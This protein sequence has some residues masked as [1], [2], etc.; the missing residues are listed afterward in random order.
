MTGTLNHNNQPTSVLNLRLTTFLDT[1]DILI[2]NQA[3]FRKEHS[4]LE[5]IFVVN[6]LIEILKTQKKKLFCAFIDFSQALDNVW[7]I[8]LWRELLGSSVQGKFLRVIYN[9]YSEIKSCVSV[10]NEYSAHFSSTLGVR[11]GENVS[12]VLCSIYLNDLEDY[13]SQNQDFGVVTEYQSE[14]M[15]ISVKLGVL[16]YADDKLLLVE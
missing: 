10:K 3:G 8:G 1:H 12:P 15:F 6:T 5:Q 14:E 4:T 7:R 16:L 13:L 2:E 9:M 11:Q